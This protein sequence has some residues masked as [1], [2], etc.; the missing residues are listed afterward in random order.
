MS[1]SVSLHLAGRSSREDR[2]SCGPRHTA[3]AP[4]RGRPDIGLSSAVVAL[5]LLATVLAS[6][7]TVTT[8][9]SVPGL[10]AAAVN[11]VTNKIYVVGDAPVTIID[12]ATNTK[13]SV[14][15]GKIGVAV[16]VNPVTRHAGCG[17]AWAAAA[18]A[19]SRISRRV[20]RSNE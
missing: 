6:A 18:T 17:R 20:S 8:T 2:P 19:G 7:Q 13:V 15:T 3:G 1:P 5:L 14:D 16:A 9:I 11:P 10:L 12:G 4:R